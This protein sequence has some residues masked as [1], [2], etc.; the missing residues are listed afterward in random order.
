MYDRASGKRLSHV[1][2]LRGLLARRHGSCSQPG[3][4]SDVASEPEQRAGEV[5]E[6]EV[7]LGLLLPADEDGSP[8][9]EPT[10]GA[11]DRPAAPRMGR[12]GRWRPVGGS[13]RGD[14]RMVVAI[15]GG[16]P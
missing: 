12:A 15:D 2:F 16:L 6:A 1:T 3:G 11:L 7:V 13:A 5:D 8:T 10:A 9:G 14:E 4:E